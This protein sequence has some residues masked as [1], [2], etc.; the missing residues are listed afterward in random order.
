MLKS[1]FSHMTKKQ[2]KMLARILA[3]AGVYI[4]ALLLGSFRW[5]QLLLFV[6]AYII[7]GQDI[8]R[9]AI[10]NIGN[11]QIFDENFLMSVAS[12][13]AFLLGEY[14][15]AVAVLLFY[16]IGEWF[17]SVAV[18]HSRASI[19]SLMDIRPDYANIEQG[20]RLIQVDPYDIK[21]G[22]VIVVQPG[23]RIPLDGVVEKGHASLDTSALTGESAFRN[24]QVND[25]VISG[26]INQN[27][28]LHIKVTKE[29]DESTVAKILDMVENASNR[30]SRSEDF[31]TRFARYYTPVVCAL[32]VMLALFPSIVTGQP[33]VWIYRALT[34]LV[35]SCPCALVISV[36]LSFFG[37]IGAASNQGI[38]VKGSNYLE[39]L[40]KVK[41][42]V[43]DK[44]GTL[45]E[46]KFSLVGMQA[47]GCSEQ[48]LLELA[49]NVESFSNHPI[50]CSIKEAYDKPLE[51]H[52]LKDVEEIAGQGIKAKLG[53]HEILVGNHRL[54]EA[55]HIEYKPVNTHG[56]VVYV[57]ADQK[58]MGALEIADAIKKDA[59]ETIDGLHNM[60][61]DQTVL[62]T[63]DIEQNARQVGSALGIDRIEA[64]L[65]PNDKM[66]RLEALME[67]NPQQT[68]A[69]VGDGINDA[70]VLMRA[71]IGI[72]MGALGSDAAIEAADIVLMDDQPHKILTAMAISK[73]TFRI[74]YQ[75]IVFAI[76]VKVLIL[77]LGALGF[78]N[79]WAAVFADVGVAFLAILNA[80][81]CMWK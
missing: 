55:N 8:L 24:V 23:E 61:V 72:A 56:S 80:L 33:T 74:V 12:I 1:M 10:S 34:F 4:L 3:G 52:A 22:D 25:E 57:S 69:F 48:E 81:R 35:I 31:I 63:G 26:C 5:I 76:G 38:L 28:L 27:G 77:I 21:V 6:I 53:T 41:T 59:K 30:K 17:Q 47:E 43:F 32:A 79:M 65:M 39:S 67:E 7:L 19:A 37:G 46:G 64:Q 54:M 70:P 71:D 2:K 62:L 68:I 51:P 9:K 73:K 15:E 49:A 18:D 78:A 44:T 16:Q 14:S 58:Y 60:G 13:G 29:Y 50:A 42:M 11:R 36:P 66:D 75:N 40:S 45:T 20:D